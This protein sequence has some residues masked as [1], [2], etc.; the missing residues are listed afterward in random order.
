[1]R[2]AASESYDPDQR[3]TRPAR[4]REN[5]SKPDAFLNHGNFGDLTILDT[6][7]PGERRPPRE[8]QGSSPVVS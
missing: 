8:L 1:L 2:S 3:T 4:A 7:D 6:H 5:R